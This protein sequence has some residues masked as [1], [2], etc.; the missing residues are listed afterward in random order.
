MMVKKEIS[1]KI[2]RGKFHNQILNV[3]GEDNVFFE[4]FCSSNNLLP[5]SITWINETFYKKNTKE[6]KKCGTKIFITEGNYNILPVEGKAFI[7]AKKAKFLFIEILNEF[8][9]KKTNYGIHPSAEIDNNAEIHEKVYI[10]PNC[11]IGKCVIGEGSVFE[12]NNFIYDNVFIGKNVI[13]QAGAVVGSK[14]MSLSRDENNRL[15]SFPSLGKVIIEDDVEIGSNSVIDM[16]I[17]D[18]TKIKK[19][20]KI[21]SL[22]FVGNSVTIGENNY[23]SVCSNIN[24]SVEIG[25]INFIGSGSTI[26]NKTKIGNN[27]TIGAGAVVVKNIDNNGTWIGNPAEKTNKS[28]G[29]KL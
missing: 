22:A 26:R 29:I 20:T 24:G 10:G 16:A 25:S 18:T 12:G 1:I 11:V 2:L 17:L 19:G 3:I 4:T 15:I 5:N 27:N 8:F 21:N 13:V 23:L 6:I 28:K 7:F 14:G 9:A